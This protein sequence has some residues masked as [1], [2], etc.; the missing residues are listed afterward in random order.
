MTQH[1]QNTLSRWDMDAMLA[2]P[3]DETA[4]LACL[5]ESP[6]VSV[7]L[8][9]RNHSAYIRQA[10]ESVVNQNTDFAYEIILG[11][12]FSTDS[13]L[14]ICRELQAEYPEKIRIVTSPCQVGITA[15]F[16]RLHSRARARYCALLEGDDYWTSPDKLQ[17]QYELLCVHHDFSWCG[18]RTLNR[19][20]PLPFKESYSLSDA[21]RRFLVHT[22]TIM[23]R[24]DAITSYPSFPDMVGW[25]SMVCVVL[26]QAGRCGFLDETLSYYRRHSGGLY[27]GSNTLRRIKLA[28]AFTDVMRPYLN[29]DYDRELFDRELWICGWEFKL[30]PY[31]FSLRQWLFHV[32]ILLVEEAPR[33]FCRAPRKFLL[34]LAKLVSHPLIY[35]YFHAR[36]S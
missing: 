19:I 21:C 16:L 11:D 30:N 33:L 25:I 27:T 36:K 23:Y 5:C 4:D 31:T 17:K 13:T 22:S 20:H 34:L 12:D 32:W 10:V 15:N 24:R 18:A 1:Q 2:I 26:S 3:C 14:D 29:Y 7:L 28:Q 35:V 9:T 8:M 6:Q